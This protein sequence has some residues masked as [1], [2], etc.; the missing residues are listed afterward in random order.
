[1]KDLLKNRILLYILIPILTA[2]WPIWLSTI[3]IPAAKAN[4]TYN[5]KQYVDSQKLFNQILDLDSGRL[6]LAG[7]GKETKRFSYA[8]AVEQ[9]AKSCG[10]SPA[11]YTLSSGVPMKVGGQEVQSAD[12]TLKKLDIAR[13]AK[14]LDTIQLRW[15]NLQCSQLKLTK[16]KG[17][18][19][20]WKCN[21][22]FKYYW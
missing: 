16:I 5:K 14:F 20:S 1:M 10:I 17:K 18:E 11:N 6:E 4:W 8:Q 3:S 21:L 15:P 12:V 9:A 13:F 19:N 22:K 7:D 2:L